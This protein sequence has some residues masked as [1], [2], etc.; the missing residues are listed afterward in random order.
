M[1][2]TSNLQWKKQGKKMIPRYLIKT[3]YSKNGYDWITN[4][5]H[6]IKFKNSK[7]EAITRPWVIK[8]NKKFIMFLSLKIK[9]YKITCATSNNGKNW[10]RKNINFIQKNSRIK[11]DSKSQ[12]YASVAKVGS[13]LYM[14][15]NGNDYGKNGVGLAICKVKDFLKKI[16]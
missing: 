7:E 4:K 2:Y 5:K 14:F 3:G 15:Y 10:R 11:F 1:Y 8:L 13:K 16:K 6:T 9:N 12:E